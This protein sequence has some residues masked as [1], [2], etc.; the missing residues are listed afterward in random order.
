M[1]NHKTIDFAKLHKAK[2]DS[3]DEADVRVAP[4]GKGDIYWAPDNDKLFIADFAGTA[5]KSYTFGSGGSGTVARL[6][7]VGD[8][9]A[10]T[11]TNDQ[12]LFYNFATTNWEAKTLPNFTTD[13]K[14]TKLVD[15]TV[16]SAAKGDLIA[17]TS[18]NWVNVAVGSN[19]MVL[20]AD[21]SSSSGI[22]WV[23]LDLADVDASY[24]NVTSR[25]TDPGSSPSSGKAWIYVK[26]GNLYL[27]KSD[28]TVVGPFLTT[29]SNGSLDDLTDVVVTSG[30]KGDLIAKTTTNWVN[31]PVGT[32]GQLLVAD[33]TASSGVSWQTVA[34]PIADLELMTWLD[35]I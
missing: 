13:F 27:K 25:S 15:I 10:S 30:A 20:Q 26:T 18:A 32:N 24:I 8:V 17:K 3:G 4:E 1:P 16:T 12:I 23:V 29:A 6:D 33:S 22:N 19:K 7:N 14:P 35:M 11:P 21:S 31:V 2:F 28:G 9:D 5:W 34:S